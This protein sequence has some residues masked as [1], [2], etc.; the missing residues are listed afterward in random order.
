MTAGFRNLPHFFRDFNPH[1]REARDAKAVSG[2]R[3]SSD[4]N[5]HERE[6]RDIASGS[7]TGDK[8]ILIHTSVKLVTVSV[9]NSG[10]DVIF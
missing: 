1:E 8:I 2:S 5:P 9:K 3:I 4:F 10:Q 6:A 7:I